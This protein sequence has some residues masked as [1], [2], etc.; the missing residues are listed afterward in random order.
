VGRKAAS[1]D[2]E[3]WVAAYGAAVEYIWWLDGLHC[4]ESRAR[5]SMQ[6][7]M[8][9][10][11]LTCEYWCI[12][13]CDA[14]VLWHTLCEIRGPNAWSTPVNSPLS[15]AVTKECICTGFLSSQPSEVI[16]AQPQPETLLCFRPLTHYLSHHLEL[17]PASQQRKIPHT[18]IFAD[19]NTATSSITLCAPSSSC[20]QICH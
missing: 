1:L 11:T 10:M 19:R 9:I 20:A 4:M 12:R 18:K 13:S 5:H 8:N 2:V 15:M 6:N 17:C 3:I 16:I 7:R 14:E